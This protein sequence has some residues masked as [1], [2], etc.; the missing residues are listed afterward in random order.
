MER[1][2]VIHV[3]DD[4]EAMRKSLRMVLESAGLASRCYASSEEFLDNYTYTPLGCILLDVRMPGINGLELQ[5]HLSQHNINL[6]III[7]T[8][9][10]DVPTAIRAMK[11]GAIDFVEKP[12]DQDDLLARIHLC[13][14]K[15]EELKQDEGRR[16]EGARLDLLTEREREVMQLLVNGKINKVIAAELGISTRTV[17]AHRAHIMEKLQARTVSD[18]VRI[19]LQAGL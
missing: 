9:Y 17:E 3:V 10:A 7:M 12:F 16:I 18:V 13:I 2:P 15:S 1:E 8:G 19:A 6:P 5:Q 11:A 4:N 14:Q